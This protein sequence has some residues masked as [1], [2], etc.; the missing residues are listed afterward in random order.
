[1]EEKIFN[2]LWQYVE[3]W[4]LA[5]P[6]L[7]A[8]HFK[9]KL[10]T[11]KEF[12][13]LTDN[14]AKA[15]LSLGVKK[16]DII[17][18]M[19][20]A[21]PEYLFS[22]IAADKIGAVICALDVKYKSADLKKFISHL[23][24]KLLIALNHQE[25]IDI[26]NILQEIEKNLNIAHEILYRIVGESKTGLSFEE[27]LQH[28][29]MADEILKTAKLN[30]N[31]TDD[32]LIVFTGGTTGVPKAAMLSKINVSG[33]AT[34]EVFHIKKII[35]TSDKAPRLKSIASL[36]PSHVGG[37]VELMGMGIVGGMEL[38]VNDIWSP[39]H[40]LKTIQEEK[41]EW[42]GAVPTM[43]A[44]MLT[45]PELQTYDLSSLKLAILSGEKL[46]TELL[47]QIYN[48]ICPNLLVGYGST[49]AG[50]EV[51]FTEPGED[52]ENIAN[53]YVGKPLLGYQ[54]KIVDQ[55]D[56][57]L[58]ADKEG[59]V[60]VK[61]DFTIKKY[62]KMPQEDKEGFTADGYCRTGDLGCLAPDG[63][64]YIKGR[65]KHII[66]VGSYTVMPSEIEEV[67]TQDSSV[68]LAAAIGV[69]DKILGEV[70]WLVVS[71]A[72]ES[73]ID[74]NK[75]IKIC[76]NQLAKFKV[77]K[78]VII[79]EDLPVTHIGKINRVQ[80]QN[81]IIKEIKGGLYEQ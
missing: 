39:T 33:M 69:P 29:S 40:T 63:G 46:E 9:N 28:N 31:E 24:P 27:M 35:K 62:F 66:R 64:L 32:M 60:L 11:W 47:E 23:E 21:S 71:P 43:Y 81:E 45:K 5:G 68:G 16:G 67:V 78:H 65:K 13:T 61:G 8:I 44:I 26:A 53:G 34:A 72:A 22:L 77:P 3:H 56:N 48:N 41:I 54:I 6:D 51:T 36:P 1:M 18:T 80:L 52:F 14:L 30:Q 59:E 42:M 4:A 74:T 73:V 7:A 15:F 75:L 25:D 55:N 49:E 20:P 10:F 2:Y 37:T 79:K 50:S 12:E 17:A 19:L 58:P 76:E 70:V 57:N 38:F